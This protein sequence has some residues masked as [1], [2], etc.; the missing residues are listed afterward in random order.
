MEPLLI[1]KALSNETRLQILE[2]LRDPQK[3]LGELAENFELPLKCDPNN[4]VCVGYIQ[5]KSGLAQSVISSYLKTLQK[6]GLLESQRVG[7]WTYYRRN[8]E[9]IRLFSEYVSRQ[10]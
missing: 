5:E 2:W 1:Y 8:E 9:T 6:A 7:Q 3:H 10:L 4:G